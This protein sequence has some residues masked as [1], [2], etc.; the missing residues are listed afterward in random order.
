MLFP[1]MPFPFTRA[2]MRLLFTA[3]AL[4]AALTARA[5]ALEPLPDDWDFTLPSLDGGRF[6]TASQEPGPLLINFWSVDC[7]PCLAEMPL[8]QQLADGPSGWHACRR[9][10]RDAAR[11]QH[12]ARRA[13]RQRPDGA[14]ARGGQYPWRL[15]I[16]CAHDERA[17]LR[18]PRRTAGSANTASIAGPM[19]ACCRATTLICAFTGNHRSHAPLRART[20]QCP[21][22]GHDHR[23]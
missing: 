19:P 13:R 4:S 12:F 8:L 7:A 3:L 10:S 22:A 9:S 18:P 21:L 17:A 20:R 2:L 23:R 15:A 5:Q 11:G 16:Y 1:R 6:I 14:H